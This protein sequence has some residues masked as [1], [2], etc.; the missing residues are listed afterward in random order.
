MI[1]Q[2]II[3][4]LWRVAAGFMALSILYWGLVA[5]NRYVS[6]SHIVVESLQTPPATTFD[7]TSVLGGTAQSKDILLLQDYLLSADMLRRLDEKLK[8]RDHYSSSYDLMSRM[9][10]RDVSFEWFLRHYQSRV[11]AEYDEYSGILII[12]A[13][14]YTQDMAHAIG[15]ALVEEGERFMNELAHRLARE[16]VA[17]AEREVVAVSQ[18]MAQARQTLLA[19]QNK[20]GLVSPTGTVE[21]LSA[22]AARL[23][24]ELSSLQT[25][26]RALESYL[27]PSAPDLVEINAQVRALEQ[28]LK[29]E[30]ARLAGANGKPTLNRVA[31]EYD[32]LL[33]EAFFQ[34]DVYRTALAALERA[35]IDANR[36][37][38]KLSVIQAPTLPDSSTEPARLYTIVAF[39]LG[40][41][42]VA[43]ILQ[44]L[45]DIVREHRD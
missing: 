18:R 9:M 35:R 44:L 19:F 8:L 40:T 13:Q 27:T 39:L 43:G 1:Y 24:G 34:Q 4:W 5:A 20:H 12:R 6:E 45:L 17:Y 26:R 28:Q 16:Q 30:R 31:E 41:I 29:A 3:R 33:L 15:R 22:V 23:E 11:E 37:L 21:S 10:R 7:L 32:R 2:K 36:T 14:A 38:K 42:I 25:R